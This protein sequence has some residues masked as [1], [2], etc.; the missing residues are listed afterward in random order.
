MIRWDNYFLGITDAVA[1][2]SS[3]LS[4]KLGAILVRNKKI[5]ST[6]YNG[7]PSGIP[8]CDT[9][10]RREYLLQRYKDDYPK[11]MLN[12]LFIP[13]SVGVCPRQVMGF[14]SGTK[15]SWCPAVHAEANC[16]A[17]AA[18]MGHST[19]GCTLYMNNDITPCKDCIGLLI[20][21]GIEEVV[22]KG[23]KEYTDSF[24]IKQCFIKF[25]VIIKEN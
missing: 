15:L 4:R 11:Y 17:S 10:K 5:I 18:Q 23:D 8:H 13:E 14:A 21:A 19:K 6:G 3:C 2:K 22:M 7:P 20:N 25:R 16:V 1:T 12:G 9:V 24:I